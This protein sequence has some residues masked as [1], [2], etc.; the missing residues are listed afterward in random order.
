VTNTA[1]CD[2]AQK[3]WA[4]AVDD[5]VAVIAAWEPLGN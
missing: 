4:A 5:L 1:Q 3:R 2:T